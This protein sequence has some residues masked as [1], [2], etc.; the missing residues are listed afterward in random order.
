MLENKATGN[1]NFKYGAIR[2]MAKHTRI[3]KLRQKN[4]KE[5]TNGGIMRK[6]DE[7]KVLLANPRFQV[8]YQ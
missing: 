2:N 4:E 6:L 8:T 3:G 7:F 1:A 5:Q